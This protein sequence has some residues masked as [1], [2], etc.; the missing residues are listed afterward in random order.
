MTRG[1][2][3]MEEGEKC[4][5]QCQKKKEER[6]EEGGGGGGGG[7]GGRGREGERESLLCGLALGRA[8][9]I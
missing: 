1:E 7:G 9:P 3:K 8:Q 2:V 4:T 6:G 5:K